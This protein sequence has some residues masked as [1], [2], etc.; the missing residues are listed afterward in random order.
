MKWKIYQLCSLYNLA[1]T[2]ILFCLMSYFLVTDP[3]SINDL[4][5]IFLYVAVLSI[6][7]MK[8]WMGYRLCMKLKAKEANSERFGVAFYFLWILNIVILIVFAIGVYSITTSLLTDS[9]SKN[10]NNLPVTA[11]F[12]LSFL[13]MFYV[14]CLD[15]PIEKKATRQDDLLKDFL[16]PEDQS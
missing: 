8:N 5:Y 1:A 12:Y 13:T 10:L 4:V 3:P 16:Q 11:A 7:G 14:I 6:V 15:I 9:R 2:A